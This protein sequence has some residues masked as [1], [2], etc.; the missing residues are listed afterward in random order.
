M[1]LNERVDLLT[2]QDNK[3]T[4]YEGKVKATSTN[5]L[6]QLRKYW[7]GCVL[8]GIPPEDGVLIAARHPKDVQKL[9][10]FLNSQ[11]GSDDRP[12]R[13]RLTT[14]KDEGISVP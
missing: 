3:I 7:D 11:T 9:V 4:I 10:D 8:D 13:L 1:D 14:W 12:Y 6:Y 5:D 2:C